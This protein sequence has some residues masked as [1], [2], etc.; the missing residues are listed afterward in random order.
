M[1]P[2]EGEP[3]ETHMAPAFL[4]AHEAN[5]RIA[6]RMESGKTLNHRQYILIITSTPKVVRSNS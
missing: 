2:M 5:P 1:K 4:D 3:N 6:P